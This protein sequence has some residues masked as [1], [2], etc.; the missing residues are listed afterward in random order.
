MRNDKEIV[1]KERFRDIMRVVWA[2]VFIALYIHFMVVTGPNVE[3]KDFSEWFDLL[4]SSGKLVPRLVAF[5]LT[6]YHALTL[7]LLLDWLF[8]SLDCERLSNIFRA[9]IFLALFF[10]SHLVAL[11]ILCVFVLWST[12]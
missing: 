10:L 7:C 9:G 2:T 1:R 6:V 8:P 5:V 11:G 12:P 4:T 3:P